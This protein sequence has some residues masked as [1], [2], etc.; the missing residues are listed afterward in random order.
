MIDD[1]DVAEAIPVLIKIELRYL[2]QS[3]EGLKSSVDRVLN[4][5]ETRIRE[6]NDGRMMLIGAAAAAGAIGGILMRLIFK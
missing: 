5:H 4:D 3:F 1:E 2:K 6:L